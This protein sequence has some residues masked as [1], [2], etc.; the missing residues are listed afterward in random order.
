M[1]YVSDKEIIIADA[2]SR[3]LIAHTFYLSA[4]LEQEVEAYVI[5]IIQS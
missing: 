4:D 3:I 5:H 2:F 1:E